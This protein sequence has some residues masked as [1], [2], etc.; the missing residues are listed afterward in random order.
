MYKKGVMCMDLKK[1]NEEM[2]GFFDEKAGGYDDVHL[3]MMGN[4]RAITEMLPDGVEKVLDLGAGTGLELIPLF[5]RFPNARVTV[6]DISSEMLSALKKRP[7]ADRLDII[8]ADFFSADFGGGYDAVISSAALHHFT[9]DEKLGLYRRIYDALNPGGIFVNSDRYLKTQWEE[10]ETFRAFYE[11]T[12]GMRHFDTP[13]TLAN[14]EKLLARAGF[15]NI[16]SR[17]LNERYAIWYGTK[18]EDKK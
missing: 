14:E 5:E 8:Q 1:R 9:G 6:V 11:N 16:A 4:K 12:H 13:L 3:L 10:D 15:V 17:E 18:Q 2:R 7:F